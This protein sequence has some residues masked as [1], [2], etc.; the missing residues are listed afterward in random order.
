MKLFCKIPIKYQDEIISYVDQY[1]S[2]Q[3]VSGAGEVV[4]YATELIDE[5]YFKR[6]IESTIADIPEKAKTL[7]SKDT[8]TNNSVL[9]KIA[10]IFQKENISK[11]KLHQ[12]EMKDPKKEF[13]EQKIETNAVFCA[14][15]CWNY[16]RV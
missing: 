9:E 2:N 11:Q 6:I 14:T 7:P 5:Y 13:I 3:N 12:E 1:S 4:A 16:D 10:H 8:T 15:Y